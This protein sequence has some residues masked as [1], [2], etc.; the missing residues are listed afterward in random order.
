MPG[1]SGKTMSS[2]SPIVESSTAATSDEDGAARVV[3]GD[4]IV[5]GMTG[6]TSSV[7]LV[8]G[9][10]LI[11]TVVGCIFSG[12]CVIVRDS[13]VGGRAGIV[14]GFVVGPG[15][16][17]SSGCVVVGSVD[18]SDRLLGFTR[19]CAPAGTSGCQEKAGPSGLW[20]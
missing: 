5:V 9:L 4:G 19:G 15:L 12:F 13:V 11:A 10:T 6:G 16:T 18:S 1:R 20:A 3:G 7:I 17:T 8:V 14:D 2:Q